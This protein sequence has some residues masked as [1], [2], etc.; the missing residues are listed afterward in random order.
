MSTTRFLLALT[1]AALLAACGSS[2]TPTSPSPTTST[3]TTPSTT[4]TPSTLTLSGTV[5]DDA[6]QVVGGAVLTIVDGVNANKTVTTESTG[7]YSLTGLAAGAFT[8]RVRREGY[9]ELSRAVTLSTTTQMDFTL[10]RVRVNLAGALTGT[11]SYVTRG[12]GQ[13]TSW[14]MTATVTQTTTGSTTTVAGTFRI[15]TSPTP[16]PEFDWTGSFTGT[17]SS[18]TPTAQVLGFAHTQRSHQFGKRPMQRNPKQ[19]HRHRVRGT[20]D[21]VGTRRLDLERMLVQPGGHR[22]H[23]SEVAEEPVTWGDLPHGRAHRGINRIHPTPDEPP[24]ASH[25]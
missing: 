4:S 7:K 21:T 22:H 25:G 8:L 3:T 19:R 10:T 13:R 9:N 24:S 18:V 5:N 15:Q 6:G 20:A 23:A 1:S 14:P 2:S 11:F 17:L 12:T 16:A